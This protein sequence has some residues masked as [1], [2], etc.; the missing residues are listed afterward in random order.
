GKTFTI[1][2]DIHLESAQT[3]SLWSGARRITV[4][5]TG[6]SQASYTYAVSETAPNAPG[7]YRV[8]VTF[9]L[10]SDISS[11][12]FLLGNGSAT[13][14]VYWDNLVIEEGT[15]DG[16]FWVTNDDGSWNVVEQY[17]H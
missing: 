9:T 16:K 12:Y 7:T 10:P 15:T 5:T 17:R 2:A 4:R 14:P 1:A 11:W 6:G 8:S 3:G 13:P